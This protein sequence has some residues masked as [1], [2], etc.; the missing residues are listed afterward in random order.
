MMTNIYHST[1]AVKTKKLMWPVDLKL[2][3]A[4]GSTSFSIAGQRRFGFDST[5]DFLNTLEDIGAIAVFGDAYHLNFN[6]QEY[7]WLINEPWAMPM[8][9]GEAFIFP[10]GGRA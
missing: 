3:I 1:A 10:A 2:G 9:N 6:I 5:E 7:A 8:V 4:G